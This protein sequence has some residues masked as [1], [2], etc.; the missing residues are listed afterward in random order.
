MNLLDIIF[1]IPILWFAYRGFVRGFVIELASLVG[2]ILGIYAA[3]YFSCYAADFIDKY[4]NLSEKY[5]SVVSFIV[6]FIVVVI[7]VHLIG[8]L[9]EKLIDIVALGFLNKLAGLIFGVLKAVVLISLVLMVI[10]HFNDKLIS[11]EKK[12]NSLFYE[13]IAGIAPFLWKNLEY[14]N[15]SKPQNNGFKDDIEQDTI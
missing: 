5:L 1:I 13:P 8:K 14:F 11:A 10:N 15:F 4:F 6:T 3:L 7:L 2:L 9:L 12:K